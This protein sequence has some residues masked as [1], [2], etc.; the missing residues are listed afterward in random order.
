MTE[1]NNNKL[2]KVSGGMGIENG[3]FKIGDWVIPNKM[4]LSPGTRYDYFRIDEIEEPDTSMPRYVV[5]RYKKDHKDGT[6]WKFG[7]FG[8]FFAEELD[9]GNDPTPFDELNF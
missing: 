4:K 3:G 7:L 9:Y 5:Y 1:L 8:K 2:S 6:V